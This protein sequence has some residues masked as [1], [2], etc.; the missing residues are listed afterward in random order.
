M[1][2]R[3]SFDGVQLVELTSRELFLNMIVNASSIRDENDFDQRL[4]DEMVLYQFANCSGI[5]DYPWIRASH[6]DLKL[7]R[8]S[9]LTAR[10]PPFM[11][12]EQSLLVPLAG[13][14]RRQTRNLGHSE[15]CL[16][17]IAVR[18]LWN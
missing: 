8:I 17:D 5:I 15:G 14:G 2:Q 18:D 1:Q 16:W 4:K 7:G 3:K 10:S 11:K 6:A 13:C 12:R 9:S